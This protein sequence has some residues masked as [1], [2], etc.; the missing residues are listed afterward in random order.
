MSIVPMD[1]DMD[2]YC[3][4]NCIYLMSWSVDFVLCAPAVWP[5]FGDLE[6][7]RVDF[8]W[9]LPFGTYNRVEIQR[10]EK[11]CHENEGGKHI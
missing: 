4:Y 1:M 11:R 7:H 10:G 3:T 5:V 9:E 2:M 6:V 8:G